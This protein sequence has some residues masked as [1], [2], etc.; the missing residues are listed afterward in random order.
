MCQR[1]KPARAG[2][3]LVEL[4]VVIAI[5]GVLVA[6][7]LPAVQAARES[8]RRMSCANNLKQI[9]L[10]LHNH[11]GVYR[12]LPFSRRDALPQRSWAPDT[13]PFL[14][15]S[16]LVSGTAYDLHE[17]WWRSTTYA[18]APIP[19]SSTVQLQLSIFSC[20]STPNPKRIQN[21]TEVAPEQ[22]KIG[23][24][25][26]YFTPEGVNPAINNE[27]PAGEQFPAGSDL[28]GAMRK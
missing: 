3:T 19:N 21:K 26:D 22:N 2:F 18:G 25:G 8:A 27:L 23:A 5:I 1:K 9:A 15:Q 24:C 12:Q 17:N 4:L 11:E 6:L 28:P 10:A 20:P 14:E 16:N 7:L 13:L